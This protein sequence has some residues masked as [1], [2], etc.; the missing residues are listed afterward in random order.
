MKYANGDVYI[1]AFSRGER[2]GDG[3]CV[4]ANGDKWEGDWFGDALNMNGDGTLSLLD[5]TV[6]RYRKNAAR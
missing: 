1:G 2:T 5:G 3:T 4:F 6:L